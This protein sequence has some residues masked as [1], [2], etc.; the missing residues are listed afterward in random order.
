MAIS[1]GKKVDDFTLK[2]QED[3]EVKLSDFKGKKVLLS[4]HPLAWTSVCTKQMKAL[5]KNYDLFTENNTVP[6][7][8]SVDPQ[9]S[10]KAW[11]EDMG[12]NKLDIL[13]DFWPHGEVAKELDVFIEKLG[14]SG[15]V[16][17]LLNED[18]EVEWV[19]VYEIS[20]LPNID[21]VLEVVQNG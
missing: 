18:R 13:S 4:F 20:E 21:E 9:P 3:K 2:N 19:K 5:E 1:K 6:L 7:G 16:N 17:I 14:F 10:K 15:R 8:L 11:A 12:L